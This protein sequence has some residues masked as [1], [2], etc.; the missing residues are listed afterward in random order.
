V[1]DG[2]PRTIAWSA[3]VS[4]CLAPFLSGAVERSVWIP[5]CQLWLALGLAVSLVPSRTSG[6]RE[7]LAVG[8]SRALLPIHLLFVV[9]LIP[10]PAA[11]LRGISPGSFAAHF[12]PDPGDGRFGPI[13]VSPLATLEAWLYFAGLQGLLIALLALPHSRRPAAARA[14]LGVILLLAAEGLWQSRSAH[15]TWFYG[16]IPNVVPSGFETASFGPYYNR[17]HFATVMALGT[18]WAAGLAMALARDRS[19][20]R[21]LFASAPAM[22]EAVVL[23]GASAFLAMTAFASGSRSGSAAAIIAVAVVL[24]RGLGTR[25]VLVPLVLAVAAFALSGP[26]AIERLLHLDV[27][28]TRWTPWMDMGRLPKFFPIFGS[29]L[30]AF[31]ATYWP[32]QMNARYEFWQHAHN[33]YLQWLIETG[34]AGVLAGTIALR[35]LRRRVD[36][37]SSSHEAAAFG[38]LVAF[39][40]QSA[41]DFPARIPANAGI[42][43]CMLALTALG[44]KR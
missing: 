14:L 35:N 33:E 17:N 4:V 40:L 42:V 28:S 44:R 8:I 29:G 15:P 10:L 24:V 25:L 30:G 41:L 34:V 39:A 43:I 13:S 7:S 32:Y 6:P 1:L 21:G 9:Q 31:A 5:L 36:F 2:V 20:L 18:G 12:L 23:G 38:A 26:A 19:G 22:T 27:V 11:V 16:R 37:G 3:F